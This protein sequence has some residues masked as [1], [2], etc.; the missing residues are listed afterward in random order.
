MSEGGGLEPALPSRGRA[1]KFILRLAWEERRYLAG[2]V[3][4]LLASNV[5]L[6]SWCVFV[7]A[8]LMEQMKLPL[9]DHLGRDVRLVLGYV[10]R[11]G[12]LEGR[13]DLWAIATLGLVLGAGVVLFK[14]GFAIC[15]AEVMWGGVRRV[16][17]RI[18]VKLLGHPLGYFTRSRSGEHLSRL[19]NDVDRCREGLEFTFND[20]VQHPV[21]FLFALVVCFRIDARFT[22]LLLVA[23]PPLVWILGRLGRRI[24][25][26][27]RRGL[28]SLADLSDLLQQTLTGMRV[29]KAFGAEERQRESLAGANRTAYRQQMKISVARAWSTATLDFLC[30]PLGSVLLA[31]MLGV[32]VARMGV[33]P[34]DLGLLA[35]LIG[36]HLYQPLRA[37]AKAYNSMENALPG[38]QRTVQMLEESVTMSEAPDAV[39]L[40]GLRGEVEFRGVSFS[41]GEGPTLTGVD[42]RV[43]AG[44]RVAVVGPSGAGKTTLLDLIPRFHDATAGTVLVDGHDVRR[45]RLASLRERIGVVPQETYLF[46]DTLRSNI[47]M[48]KPDATEGEVA[49]AVEAARLTEVVSRLPQGLDTEVGERGSRLSGGERKRVAI[50]RALLRDPAI[51]ILDEA[52]SDLDAASEA[53]VHE[54]LRALMRGRTTFVIAHRLSTVREA[55]E[56][57]V[58]DAG[59]IVERGRHADLVA[60]GG[61][62]TRLHELQA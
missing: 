5:L 58:L 16:R 9:S 28:E 4:T 51:L 45:V 25:R 52:T 37:L 13:G 41:Y 47:R 21:H 27:S 39:A 11:W 54:A 34:G 1:L 17:D 7:W 8:P 22:A 60:R 3:A 38:V 46:H 2:V 49:R 56:I 40:D 14:F 48:G 61:L 59:R 26:S 57:V 20:L 29:V 62:Y 42:L 19:S 24:R 36:Q 35:L 30:Y 43:P 44:R 10:Q 23:F 53:A 32:A 55:D 15:V 50:A 31:V 6:M 12:F 33:S 18:C